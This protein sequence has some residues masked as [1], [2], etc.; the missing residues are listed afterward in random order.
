MVKEEIENSSIDF[1]GFDADNPSIEF[2]GENPTISGD[3]NT[4]VKARFTRKS[5]SVSLDFSESGYIAEYEREKTFLYQEE[6][7]ISFTIKKG[8]RID[9]IIVKDE[10]GDTIS[11]LDY[12]AMS[13][14]DYTYQIAFEMPAFTFTFE[15]TIAPRDDTKYH[16]VYLFENLARNGYEENEHY[17]RIEG[18]GT[19][20]DEITGQTIGLD[21]ISIT[22]F[23]IART[24]LDNGEVYINGDGS[25][26]VEIYF[27][28]IRY[29][30]VF[31]DLAIAGINEIQ[32]L[33][34]DTEATSYGS[35]YNVYYGQEVKVTVIPKLGYTFEGYKLITFDGLDEIETSLADKTAENVLTFTVSDAFASGTIEIEDAQNVTVSKI[36]LDFGISANT[37]TT[38]QV[39]YFIQLNG[40]GEIEYSNVWT[41]QFA[42]GTT[43]QKFSAIE[44]E[45]MFE[46]NKSLFDTYNPAFFDGLYYAFFKVKIGEND[47]TQDPYISGDPEN[48]TIFEMYYVLEEV[49]IEI[50][51]NYKQ[52]AYILINGER[53]EGVPKSS[54]KAVISIS[55]LFGK[56]I[57]VKAIPLE[58]YEVTG[59]LI[60]G[61]AF[62]DPT[63][64]TLNST[65]AYEVVSTSIP[66]ND[67][68]YT[69][70][71]LFEDVETGE[72]KVRADYADVVLEGTTGDKIQAEVVQQYVR[73][74][75]GYVIDLDQYLVYDEDTQQ[76]VATNFGDIDGSGN[77]VVELRYR[78]VYLMFRTIA[79]AEGIERVDI[80]GRLS[81][82]NLIQPDDE[83]IYYQTKHSKQLIL[84]VYLKTGYE[85][86]GWKVNN[87]GRYFGTG[88]TTCVYEVSESEDFLLYAIAARK[89]IAII[90]H[91]NNGSNMTKT[92]TIT[93]GMEKEL[94]LNTFKNGRK[95]F[96]GWA[97]EPGGEVVYQDGD[98]FLMDTDKTVDLYAVWA[99]VK[100]FDWVPYALIA[101]SVL[102]AITLFFIFV[103]RR[104]RSKRVKI[105]SK[106]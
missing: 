45:T 42:N 97:T 89:Q 96:V 9:Q 64:F 61:E 30:L 77:T 38:Y 60:N 79:Y 63:S 17:P 90:F 74:I 23:T 40:E 29:A 37:N 88:S 68:K 70:R 25:T 102:L 73:T 95:K 53:Y 75:A 58:G 43:D 28:R 99:D 80:S 34:N 16:V 36:T 82:N 55:A 21:S 4:I 48:P 56:S 24:T 59:C 14:D 41:L 83:N 5:Y 69:I 93:Y 50:S 13:A 67:T 19:T 98:T 12:N 49:E 22:G 6:G 85:F 62:E 65:S 46:T 51:Y 15:I 8:Y 105:M 20:D 32:V 71:Y 104:R 1:T 52:V 7:D 54:T 33:T 84:T 18:I 47:F 87:E 91:P 100:Y 86:L 76:Y 78:L 94:E 66:R 2:A 106:Q 57:E 10:N 27:E 103:L 92:M 3:G 101:D 44:I 31:K 72:Y 11:D 26:I 35:G 81:N 39:K